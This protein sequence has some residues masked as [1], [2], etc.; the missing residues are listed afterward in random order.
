MSCSDDDEDLLG[1]WVALSD[2]NGPK[3]TLATGTTVKID[4]QEYGFVGLG[5]DGENDLLSDFWR[6][7][8]A[9]DTYGSWAKVADF[10]GIARTHAVSFSLNGYL[11]VGTG[12]TD[13]AGESA[14]KVLY[15]ND[16]FKYDPATDAWTEI[17]PMPT[18]GVIS[19]DGLRACTA[20]VLG[21]KA[22]VGFGY[23][24][25]N[26]YKDLYVFDGATETWEANTLTT[27]PGKKLTGAASFVIGNK[28]YVGAGSTNGSHS[29]ASGFYSFDGTSWTRLHV[30]TTD[31]N[32]DYSKDDDY[33]SNI[34]R[35]YTATFVMNG[36]GYFATGGQGTSGDTVWEYRP[37]NDEWF[38]KTNF[39]GTSRYRAV[40]LTIN[41]KGYVAT[42]G[43]SGSVFDDIWR[44][45]P[46]ADQSDSDN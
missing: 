45:E 4:G 23:D 6:F 36:Y 32:D 40:G 25:I 21:N 29:S 2:M 7:D 34:I 37:E 38:E 9:A 26:E 42:G 43:N 20:F 3:R 13:I 28:A 8:P 19:G 15:L 44:F 11:Y 18:E 33:G 30:L 39:E 31:D 27:F 17:D 35:S 5:R 12:Y 1:N 22:Y 14:D 16:F 46:N 24:G 10:P 41:G